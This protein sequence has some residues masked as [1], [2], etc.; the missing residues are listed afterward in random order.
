MGL[1]IRSTGKGAADTELII[2]KPSPDAKVA[3]LA[4]NPNVGK[5]TVFNN[6]TGMNQHTGNWPGKTVT[7]AQGFCSTDKYSYVL[8]DIPG[9]Y[10]LMAHSAEEEIA[11][12]FICFGGANE[13]IVVC[14]A[15][16]LERN[17]NLVLQTIE[18]CD[19]VIVCVNLMDEAKRKH[20]AIDIE[21]LEHILGVPVVGAVAREKKSLDG[22]L[23]RMDEMADAQ[24]DS[25]QPVKVHYPEE[26]EQAAELVLP[27]VK[28]ILERNGRKRPAAKWLA[29]KLLEGDTSLL[30]ELNKATGTDICKEP[31]VSGALNEAR[32]LLESRGVDP[33]TLK[34]KIVSTV[35]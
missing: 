4:G 28:E 26:I 18:I 15:T 32:R 3:A 6:L 10:S 5:S 19:E 21:K 9:T 23:L 25:R 16:C 33:N 7:N 27:A 22:L 12:N 14:D 31:A 29:L 24:A 1:T 35:V 8:V 17:L 2:R 30:E 34:D 20:I 13:I 11:R